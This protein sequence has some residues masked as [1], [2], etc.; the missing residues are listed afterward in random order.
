VSGRAGNTEKATTSK[1]L[2]QHHPVIV[3]Y[4]YPT[5]R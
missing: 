1:H 3:W 4:T 2:P 5:D